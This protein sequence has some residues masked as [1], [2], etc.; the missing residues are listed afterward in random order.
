MKTKLLFILMLLVSWN[1]TL[2]SQNTDSLIDKAVWAFA[3]HW[4]NTPGNDGNKLRAILTQKPVQIQDSIAMVCDRKLGFFV[5]K[6]R[7]YHRYIFY[8]EINNQ[9][10]ET[11]DPHY[12]QGEIPRNVLV[13]TIILT[14]AVMYGLLSL[15][16][17]LAWQSSILSWIF[18]I[19]YASI[20]VFLNYYLGTTFVIGSLIYIFK[21]KIKYFV[22]GLFPKKRKDNIKRNW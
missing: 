5:I 18:W 9:F 11:V 13:I 4:D 1:A 8:D 15:T 20:A 2:A 14:I 19:L 7:Y 21:Y 17:T 16:R 10:K 22:G 6:E 3:Q 12:R